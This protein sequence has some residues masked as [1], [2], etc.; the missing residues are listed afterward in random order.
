MIN[1]GQQHRGKTYDYVL[2]HE[3]KYCNWCL[4]LTNSYSKS[5]NEFIFYLKNNINSLIPKETINCSELPLYYSRNEEFVSLIKN[6]KIQN[7]SLNS[8]IN[9]STDLPA[10]IKGIYIDYMVRYIIHSALKIEF[11]DNRCER[12][13]NTNNT[14]CYRR[15][16]IKS[17]FDNLQQHIKDIIITSIKTANIIEGADVYDIEN[18]DDI[19]IFFMNTINE[20][21]S[22]SY[23]NMKNFTASNND[24]FNVSL[25]HSLSFGNIEAYNYFDLL[26]N[27]SDNYEILQKYLEKKINND[28]VFCNPVLNNIDLKIQADA[29]LII[30]KELIDIKCCKTNIGENITDYIQLFI[31]ACLYFIK[32]GIKCERITIFNPLLGY[33]KYIDISEWNNFDNM[34]QLLK[35]RIH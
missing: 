5:M 31:Y 22:N 19:Q 15:L 4:S 1:F 18:D 7:S 26:K 34:I 8:K 27:N 35:N 17:I 23:N 33:E 6:M 13:T 24:V 9:V 16:P 12:Y 14:N 28:N 30:D 2:K 21:I 29:D 32:T 10:D 3:K 20:I 11:S 25:C